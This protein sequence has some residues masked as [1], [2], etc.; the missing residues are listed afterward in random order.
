MDKQSIRV[1]ILEVLNRLRDMIRWEIPKKNWKI[2]DFRITQMFRVIHFFAVQWF[3]DDKK[4]IK[5]LDPRIHRI[6]IWYHVISGYFWTK[7]L[8]S[9][10]NDLLFMIEDIKVNAI[11]ALR[12]IPMEGYQRCFQQLQICWS[13]CVCTEK[14]YFEGN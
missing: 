14:Q 7:N 2:A 5:F 13:K 4:F 10:V 12:A 11:A 3:L 1:F 8:N 9:K 6:F